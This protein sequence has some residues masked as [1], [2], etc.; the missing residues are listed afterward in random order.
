MYFVASNKIR[1]STCR[2]AARSKRPQQH[3]RAA[4]AQE[5]SAAQALIDEGCVVISQHTDTIGPAIACEEA[6]QSKPVYHVGYNQSMSEVAP[7]TTLLASRICWE[8]YVT[9]AVDAVIAQFKRGKSDIVFKGD[10][11]GVNPDDSSDTCDLREGYAENADTSFP[12][13]HYILSG[14][15]SVE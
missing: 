3:E 5:K 7:G 1:Q 11:T 8:P 2:G 15:I 9:V 13:F 12:T 6:S 14:V 4:Y 10:Y